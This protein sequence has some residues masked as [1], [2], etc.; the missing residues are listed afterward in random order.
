MPN[1]F[2]IATLGMVSIIAG[3]CLYCRL[4]PPVY[5]ASAAAAA[6]TEPV[7]PWCEAARRQVVDEQCARRSRLRHFSDLLQTALLRDEMTLKDASERL[8][9]YALGSYPEYLD[10][11]WNAEAGSNMKIKVARNLVRGV[12]A[13]VLPQHGDAAGAVSARLERDLRELGQ[14]W[15]TQGGALR[16]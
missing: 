6:G 4:G 7:D 8:F 14:A 11:V 3:I 12:R 2:F 9:Y 16:Q 10:H 15:E 1:R 13:F 5:A